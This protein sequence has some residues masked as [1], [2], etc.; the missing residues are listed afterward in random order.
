MPASKRPAGGGFRFRPPRLADARIRSKLGL[1][2]LVPLLAIV[3]LAVLR[4]QDAS[5]RAGD[6]D[7][8]GDLT[9]LSADVSGLAQQVHLEKMAAAAL[10]ASPDAK[11]DAYNRQIVE[12][13][14]AVAQYGKRRA[15]L[16]DV[17][18]GVRDRLER[19]D[20]QLEVLAAIRKDVGNR[21]GVSV[22]EVVLRYGVVAEDLVSY[23][24]AVAQVRTDQTLADELRAAAAFSKAKARVSEQEA[25]TYAALKSGTVDS[26]Q[27]AALLATLTGQQEAFVAFS[28]SA[29]VPQRRI[30]DA[31]IAGDATQMADDLTSTL[32]RTAGQAPTVDAEDAVAV[33]GAVNDLMRW[34][35]AR[36]DEQLVADAAAIGSTVRRQVVIESAVLFAI[37][38]L[39]VGLAFVTARSMIRSLRRLRQTALGVAEHDLPEL[40]LRLRDAQTVRERSPQEI[41]DQVRSPAGVESRDEIGEV[42]RAFDTVHRE[43]V[44]VAAEQ[45]VLRNSVSSMFLS[46]AR[47]S[48]TLVDRMIGQLDRIERGEED[49]KRLAQLFQLDHLATRMRRNDE[50][51]LVLAGADTAPPRRQDAALMDVIRAAQSEIELYE[52][53]EF[54]ELD[55]GIFVAAPAVNDVVR[56]L[57]ELL[58]NA[59]RFSPPHAPVV[60]SGQRLGDRTV[61]CIDDR[62]L[63][64]AREQLV[65]YNRRLAEPTP[66]DVAAFRLMGIAVVGRLAARHRI[67]VQ[68]SPNGGG[69]TSA[70][71]MLPASA[72]VLQRAALP[73]RAPR[74]VEAPP[75]PPRPRS[76]PAMPAVPAMPAPMAN[77]SMAGMPMAGMPMA[78]MP[79]AGMAM[80]EDDTTELPIFREI[81][82]TWFHERGHSVMTGP[83][84]EPVRAQPAADGNGMWRTRADDGWRAA[85]AAQKPRFEGS[86]ESGLPI[87]SPQ[88]QLVPGGVPEKPAA[89]LKRPSAEELRG[90]LSS[91]QRGV[92]R[93][94]QAGGAVT[95][96]APATEEKRA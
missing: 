96:G 64:I 95:N 69:G 22:S 85:A 12:T 48:Q 3:T 37:L 59:T 50:N 51:V 94:R 54:G 74:P 19:I 65:E 18:V 7:T 58:D 80:A 46:L 34:T 66:V 39:V 33:F 23:R 92:Q 32:Q 11:A 84:P 36:L 43:A 52:R 14:A 61:V 90:L 42:V 28:L 10:L 30:V 5:S 82:E 53:I 71:V 93:G 20:D 2:L 79:M 47:R 25:V 45:A 78:G 21:Q 4:L 44:R 17:P 27:L 91:Y 68:L 41:A 56:L 81:E 40:V 6:A 15:T 38:A 70:E 24:E 55:D 75:A 76:A 86:T 77:S 35:E 1:I 73:T 60:V 9:R 63:G 13:D 83:A 57:A 62:G 29:S 88:A 31:S 16:G 87:R 26:H 89:K 67:T 49:P 72:L 8:V